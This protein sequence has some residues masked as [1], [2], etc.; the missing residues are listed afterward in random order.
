[1]DIQADAS[2]EKIFDSRPFHQTVFL[3]GSNTL[4]VRT[5]DELSDGMEERLTFTP[6]SDEGEWICTTDLVQMG[7][8]KRPRLLPPDIKM[9]VF[10][11]KRPRK[12]GDCPYGCCHKLSHYATQTEELK[13]TKALY[14][15][16]VYESPKTAVPKEDLKIHRKKRLLKRFLQN[17]NC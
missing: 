14:N 7:P 12:T 8:K 13:K 4:P 15:P 5:L 9:Y 6:D 17:Q 10:I 1:M 11:E 3:P 16:T 2:P